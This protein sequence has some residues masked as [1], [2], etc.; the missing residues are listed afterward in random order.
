M[1]RGVDLKFARG[2]GVEGLSKDSDKYTHV[3]CAV[4]SVGCQHE[5]V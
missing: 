1:A 2:R 4:P 3:H 5:T